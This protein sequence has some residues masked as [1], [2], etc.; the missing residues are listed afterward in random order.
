MK[1][2]T[3]AAAID[4]G[5]NSVRMLS[6]TYDGNGFSGRKSVTITRLGEGFIKRKRLKQAAMKRTAEAVRAFVIKAKEDGV[7]GPVYGYATSAARE[8]K[9]G[10]EFLDMLTDIDGFEA[11]I[12]DGDE[13]ALLAYQGA[14]ILGDVVMDIGGGSTELSRMKEGKLLTQSVPLGSVTSLE[15]YAFGQETGPISIMA[16]AQRLQP[17]VQKLDHAVMGEEMAQTL[18]GVGGTATQ[19][20]MLFLKLPEYDPERVHGFPMSI[21]ELDRLHFSLIRMT[22]EQRKAMPG[23]HPKRADVIVAGCLIARMVM[24]QTGAKTLIAS[25][26][27]GLDAYLEKRYHSV[28][29]KE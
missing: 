5:T 11:Q 25:E 20:A 17:L 4:I 6:A 15:K 29:D 13:E 3:K 7:T 19:L 27:D 24:M 28:L 16:M 14:A 1:T 26:R 18:V 12:I 10:Q 22:T 9:N 2:G 23:M 8:A 21:D